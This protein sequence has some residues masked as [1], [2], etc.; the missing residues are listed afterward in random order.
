MKNSQL[1]YYS[2]YCKK[3]KKTDC[4]RAFDGGGDGV[5]MREETDRE[6]LWEKGNCKS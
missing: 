3:K 6:K 4:S 1:I 2:D 5:G